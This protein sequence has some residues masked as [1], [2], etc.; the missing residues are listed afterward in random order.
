MN[1]EQHLKD[2]LNSV[3]HKDEPL[4]DLLSNV[5]YGIFGPEV[6]LNVQDELDAIEN[7]HVEFTQQ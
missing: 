7:G 5:D 4:K 6:D 1:H 2:Q 3:K